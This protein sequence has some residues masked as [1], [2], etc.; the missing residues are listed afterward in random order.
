MVQLYRDTPEVA[1]VGFAKVALK[2]GE[3]KRVRIPLTR[4]R[5]MRWSDSGWTDIAPQVQLRVA[6]DAEDSGVALT[7]KVAELPQTGL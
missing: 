1:L 7:V 3:A 5:F 6:R 4:R 2:P